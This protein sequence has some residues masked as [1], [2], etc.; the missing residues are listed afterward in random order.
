MFATSDSLTVPGR[1]WTR[2]P[3]PPVGVM[4]PEMVW[5]TTAGPVSGI[6]G[7]VAKLEFRTAGVPPVTPMSNE[8]FFTTSCVSPKLLRP[9]I[10]FMGQGQL[11]GEC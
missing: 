8:P 11:E 6:G 3:A 9:S 5:L 7:S 10:S 1:N 4:L 2:V